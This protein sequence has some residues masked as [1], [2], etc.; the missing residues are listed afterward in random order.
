L[1]NQDNA[2]GA[3]NSPSVRRL[4]R[5]RGLALTVSGLLCFVI[6]APSIGLTFANIVATI[7]IGGA[8][9]LASFVAQS[10]AVKR[11]GPAASSS[12]TS[13]RGASVIALLIALPIVLAVLA[14]VW[15]A[16]YFAVLIGIPLGLGAAS[17]IAGYGT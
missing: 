5:E 13:V 12:G 6:V 16:S 2:S 4:Y 3:G 8:V 9:G 15:D 1:A 11:V 14:A 7:I 10:R 17:L